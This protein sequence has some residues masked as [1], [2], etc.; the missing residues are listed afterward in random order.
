[1]RRFILN[2][3]LLSILT[4]VI[5]SILIFLTAQVLPGNVGRA[6][7]G[8]LADQ[9]SVDA[10]N[11]ELGYDR[12]LFT[13]Y[14]DWISGV[15]TGDLGDSAVRS[16]SVGDILAGA[17]GNS[18]KL[19]LLAFIIVVPLAVLGGVYAAL[20]EGTLRD[21]LISLGGLSATA[22][23]DFVWAVVLITIL[24][25]GIGIFKPTATAPPGSNVFEQVYYLI[26]PAICLVFVL[27]G[28]IARMAR[29]GTLEALDADYTRTAVI[30]GLPQR[31]VIRGHVLRNSLL[32]TIAVVATQ[33]GYLIGGLVVIEVIFNYNGLGRELL[34]AAQ[35]NDLPLLQSGVLIVGVVYL[36]A[37]LVADI[38]YSV[39]NPRVRLRSGGIAH[40]RDAMTATAGNPPTA[41]PALSGAR[42]DIATSE[43]RAA[44]RERLSLLL[45]VE[46]VHRRVADRAVLGV[47]RHLRALDRP[48]RPVHHRR[49]QRPR[50]PQRRPLVRHRPHRARRAVACACGRSRHPHRRPAGDDPRHRRRRLARPR[51][52][53]L[54]RHRRQRHQP[55]PRRLPGA[56]NRHHRSA[57]HR[58]ARHRVVDRRPRH[59]RRVRT[60]HRPHR[61]CRRAARARDGVR[62]RGAAAKREHVLHPL[63]RDPAQRDGADHGRVH[64]PARLRD[65]HGRHAEL[66]RVRHPA[67]RSGL[68]SAGLRPLRPRQRRL[69]VAGAVPLAR[70]RFTRDR[71]QH[72][73]RRHRKGIRTMSS[74]LSS[75]EPA[76][77]G[78]ANALEL[79]DLHVDYR[80][81]GNWKSVLRGVTLHVAPGESYGLVGESGCGKS[82]AAFAALKY[83][84]RNGRVSEGGITVAGADLM[85]MSDA[86]VRKLRRTQVSM[87]YQNPT[88]ALNPTIHVGEQV[89]EVFTLQGIG[90]SDAMKRAE[91]MLRKVQISDPTGVMRRYPH[92]LSGGMNQRVVIA[93]A[94]AKDPALLILDEPTTGLDAT[95]EAEV[96]ELVAT[97]RQEFGTSVLFISHNLDVILRMCDRVG[98]LYAGRIVEEGT[99]ADVFNNPRHPYT[100]GLLR[101]IPA[102]ER[103]RRTASSTRSLDSFPASASRCPDASSPTAARS[104]RTSACRK[105]RRS[106]TSVTGH[107]SRCHFH[108]QAQ[109]LPR[110]TEPVAITARKDRGE[111]MPV[112]STR[113]VR[114]TFYQDGHEVRAVEDITFTLAPGETLG[115]VG[116]SGSGKTTLARLLL[117]LTAPD[118]GSIVELNGSPVAGSINKR[119]RDEVRD[120]QIVFQNP[121]AALNRRFSIKRI[122]SRALNRL[123]GQSG[124]ELDDKVRDL[125]HSVRFDTRLIRAKPSQL[126]GGLKQ[127]VA[128][129]RAFAGDPKI[130]VCDE[131]TSALDVSVQAAILNLLAELQVEND[132]AYLFISHDLGVVRYL[133]DRI[134]VL[135]L[136]RLMEIGES[137]TVFGPP[138]HPYTEALLSTVTREDGQ[139]RNRIKLEGEIPSHAD[140][141]S[142]C[143]F[144]TRCPRYIGDICKTDEPELREVEP[145]HF[146]R[147]HHDITELGALQQSRP[148]GEATSTPVA[149]NGAS[150]HATDGAAVTTSDDVTDGATTVGDATNSSGATPADGTDNDDLLG[151]HV[152]DPPAD[153]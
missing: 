4:L 78:T 8:P 110:D 5:L 73:G 50:L 130:V 119:G 90:H 6:I 151:T 150:T 60:D 127:R 3:I 126:S 58:C 152:P 79:D 100:V 40:D 140:P 15:F 117:G 55:L 39:L 47:L 45:Q 146:W 67:A 89:A 122:I 132:T 142:G 103:R 109:D 34:I 149:V 22:I 51:H 80:V 106:T 57:R 9:A 20:K 42:T 33:L 118:E 91:D 1:M 24:P 69:L 125:A 27:F 134:A 63:R 28:Y 41:D 83:L 23:P 16:R 131:P 21:R 137:E 87:V 101:C 68:G 147:C 26:L 121:D 75:T 72:D 96:L 53:L 48:V 18:A 108:E 93:M 44:Q 76:A 128:I 153:K 36:V 94:L 43:E 37:T 84:P 14:W 64:R 135:Y 52:R 71:R 113:N 35:R 62:R 70:N 31:S 104:N 13:Q 77:T 124:Q 74:T 82:T 111:R 54:P 30:K 141:P 86:D 112:V 2:R 46:G 88:S 32:P 65:L 145:G 114:K 92:Q 99:S 107:S 102:P 11:A 123:L 143:V 144:H 56:A 129:A 115:L 120:L 98:V 7:L 138:Q 105:S 29:A 81:R 85:T 133:S 59:R 95:V 49:A 148:D 38:M 66:P 10:K 139:V 25:L 97:L 61:A 136:G 12:G 116:E 17:I 19:A